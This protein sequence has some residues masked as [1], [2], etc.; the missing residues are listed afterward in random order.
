MLL[1]GVSDTYYDFVVGVLNYAKRK[2]SSMEAMIAFIEQHP[3]AKSDD[4]IEY[5]IQRDDYFE[6]AQRVVGVEARAQA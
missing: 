4:I 2:Q 1:N 5:M 3:E 6:H